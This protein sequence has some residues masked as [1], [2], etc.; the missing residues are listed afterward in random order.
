MTRMLSISFRLVKCI[1]AL[2]PLTSRALEPVLGSGVVALSHALRWIVRFPKYFE[3][4][5]K[6]DFPRF[7]N[8][9]DHFC[10]IRATRTNFVVRWVVGVSARVANLRQ[11]VHA[12]IEWER[13][14]GP[15]IHPS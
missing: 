3:H 5:L 4:L 7:I 15:F 8:D 12:M 2:V 9:A 11:T 14:V 10:V 6:C 13:S 1:I